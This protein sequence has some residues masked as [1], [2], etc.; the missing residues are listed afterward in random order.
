MNRLDELL[1][2]H[3]RSKRLEEDSVARILA[4]NGHVGSDGVRAWM[5]ALATAAVL[6]LAFGFYRNYGDQ[7]DLITRVLQEISMNHNKLLDIEIAARD[8]RELQS[9]LDRLD[10]EVTP[11]PETKRSFALI[12]GRYCSIQGGLAAQLK[13]K[14]ISSGVIHTLYVT[15]LT[16]SLKQIP[17]QQTDV[18]GTRIRLWSDGGRFFALAG[19]V[20]QLE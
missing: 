12:G 16:E 8:Y 19:G 13:V 1:K 5:P 20:S 15:Q 4:S 6:L 2:S 14:H 10:F 7:K 17:S 3:F 11:D 18:A 9:R